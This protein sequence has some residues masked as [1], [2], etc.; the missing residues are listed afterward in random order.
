MRWTTTYRS[1]MDREDRL[2]AIVG[3][4]ILLV[5][6]VLIFGAW[7]IKMHETE[8]ELQR[9]AACAQYAHGKTFYADAKYVCDAETQAHGD[10]SLATMQAVDERYNRVAA[11]ER[12]VML[13]ITKE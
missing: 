8:K 11:E 9:V 13:G 4:S 12:Q 3:I 1:E 5:S 7:R 6:L 2:A 10:Y